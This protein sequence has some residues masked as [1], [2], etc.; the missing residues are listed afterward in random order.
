[1][2]IEN[3]YKK[4]AALIYVSLGF[5][6]PNLVLAE[7]YGTVSFGATEFFFIAVVMGIVAGL[8][9]QAGEK[10]TWAIWTL[11]VSMGLGLLSVGTIAN[12]FE[13]NLLFGLVGLG[14]WGL[15][16]CALFLMHESKLKSIIGLNK[17]MDNF[18]L[19]NT[20][21]NVIST[22]AFEKTAPNKSN[23]QSSN[24]INDLGKLHEL[25]KSGAIS[26]D[27][28]DQQKKHLLGTAA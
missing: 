14:Q 28:F 9:Y 7:K 15:Q 18:A 27:E 13:E 19:Q 1:M 17:N 2:K 6:I 24:V 5:G 10:K 16:F 3:N 11:T 8:A 25:L 23:D 12:A 4:A 20:N 26:Q 22:K 21:N